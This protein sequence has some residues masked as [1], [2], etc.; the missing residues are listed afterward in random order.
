MILHLLLLL[1]AYILTGFWLLI[2]LHRKQPV[3]RTNVEW[4]KE[5]AYWYPK[6]VAF[7]AIAIWKF[8]VC[9]RLMDYVVSEKKVV[10]EPVLFDNTKKQTADE[11]SWEE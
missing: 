6:L 11:Q 5:L 3:K 9:Q 8:N 10:V 1:V 4:M 7:I 2:Q